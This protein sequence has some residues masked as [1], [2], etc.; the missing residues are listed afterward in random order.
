VRVACNLR[1]I[2]GDRKL[3]HLA[4]QANVHPGALSE[5]ERGIRLPRDTDVAALEQAYGAPW[6]AWYG[7][8]AT[9]IAQLDLATD[10]ERTR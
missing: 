1:E 5:I 8:L 4:A 7:R 6:T 10:E 3:R 9:P 2:R